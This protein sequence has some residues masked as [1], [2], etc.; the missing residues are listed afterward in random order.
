MSK[1]GPPTDFAC[2]CPLG[3]ECSK[4]NHRLAWFKTEQ[5]A[6]EKVLHHLL[7]SEYHR[8]K[9]TEQQAH[10]LAAKAPMDVWPDDSKVEAKKRRPSEPSMPPPVAD[11][12]AVIQ[13][14]VM[15]AVQATAGIAPSTASSS[16]LAPW[17][18]DPSETEAQLNFVSAGITRATE[19][20]S[21]SVA[22]V[23]TAA[24]MARQAAEAFEQESHNLQ[25]ALDA[26]Q[27]LYAPGTL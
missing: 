2:Y 12:S 19:H 25:Q 6:R 26:I 8:D 24:R 10:E 16:S 15:Q 13:Q 18:Q 4:K 5:E 9:V 17:H 1:R 20:I 27:A 22:A 11:V 14:A 7:N 21:K 3:A 23:K